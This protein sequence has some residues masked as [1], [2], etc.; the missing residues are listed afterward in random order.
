M[1]MRESSG[2]AGNIEPLE[3]LHLPKDKR[4]G[5]KY[6]STATN[7]DGKEKREMKRYMGFNGASLIKRRVHYFAP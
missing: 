3:I 1:S 5:A 4:D 6:I 2:A 7:S